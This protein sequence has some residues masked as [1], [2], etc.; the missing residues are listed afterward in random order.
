M[1]VAYADHDGLS[2]GRCPVPFTRLIA[3]INDADEYSLVDV[4]DPKFQ[5]RDPPTS[6][7]SVIRCVKSRERVEKTRTPHFFSRCAVL[8]GTF[9][10]L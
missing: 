7:L 6:V 5:K 8:P 1:P 4:N 9:V 2:T 10:R 3:F